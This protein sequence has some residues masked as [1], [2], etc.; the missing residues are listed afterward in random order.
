MHI[1][2]PAS[3]QR[4]AQGNT[5]ISWLPFSSMIQW[6]YQCLFCSHDGWLPT[7]IK[8]RK[9]M[10][11]VAHPACKV[12]EGYDW[13]GSLKT[14]DH[15]VISTRS[16][17]GYPNFWTGQ[18]KSGH[19]KLFCLVFFPP[20]WSKQFSPWADMDLPEEEGNRIL[21]PNSMYRSPDN[22][23]QLPLH[24]FLLQWGLALPSSSPVPRFIHLLQKHDCGSLLTPRFLQMA[25]VWK[26]PCKLSWVHWV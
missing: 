1:F 4:D 8:P 9:T 15:L 20:C 2:P 22:G 7:A 12:Y 24:P 6:N 5:F 25:P 3:E 23:V 10:I 18:E 19:H 14:P 26:R 17:Q 13:P 16:P 21:P 11:S